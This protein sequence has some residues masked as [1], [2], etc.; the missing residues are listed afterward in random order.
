MREK[1]FKVTSDF[2]FLNRFSVYNLFYFDLIQ[3][4]D[5]PLPILIF[6]PKHKEG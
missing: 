6:D 2:N 3:E 4:W 5:Y 1:Y